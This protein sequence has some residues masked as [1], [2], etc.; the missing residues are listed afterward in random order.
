MNIAVD[1][2]DKGKPEMIKIIKEFYNETLKIL[3][4]MWEIAEKTKNK[5]LIEFVELQMETLEQ[6]YRRRYIG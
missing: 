5:T 1:E 3:Q 2:F 6:L 4:Q